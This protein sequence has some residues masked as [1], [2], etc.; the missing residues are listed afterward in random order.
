MEEISETV[1]NL[2]LTAVLKKQWKGFRHIHGNQ[3]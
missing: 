2:I 3:E 1:I